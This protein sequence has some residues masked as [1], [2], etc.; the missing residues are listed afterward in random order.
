MSK[1]YLYFVFG[2]IAGLLVFSGC[3]S[4]SYAETTVDAEEVAYYDTYNEIFGDTVQEALDEIFHRLG[5]KSSTDELQATSF[6]SPGD[7]E[8][9]T[10]KIV[11]DQNVT[12]FERKL[13]IT[14]N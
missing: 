4:D 11:T 1:N 9:L 7:S 2:L 6:I 14:R 13:N 10:I 8:T 5:E 3:G 12:I